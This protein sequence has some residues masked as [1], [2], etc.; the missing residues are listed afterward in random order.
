MD[1]AA[2]LSSM[3][4]LTVVASHPWKKKNLSFLMTTLEKISRVLL[5][6]RQHF[7]SGLHV[8]YNHHK[9]DVVG[10]NHESR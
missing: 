6:N 9:A 4:R 7:C 10:L 8:I 3:T 5:S 1:I 2:L